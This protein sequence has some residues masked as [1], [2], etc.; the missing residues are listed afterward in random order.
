MK[1]IDRLMSGAIDMHVH[2]GPD[3]YAKRRVD[4]LEIARQAADAGMRAVVFKSHYYCTAPVA[5]MVNKCIGADVLVGSIALN[6][7]VGGLNPSALEAAAKGGAK[8]VWMPT[9]SAMGPHQKN[10]TPVPLLTKT[11][12]LAPQMGPILDIVKTHELVLATGHISA[13][14]VAAVVTEA[15]RREIKVIIT[16]PLAGP[17]GGLISIE[18]AKSYAGMGV[19]IEHCFLAC[20]PPINLNPA[21]MAEYVKA[22]GPEHCIIST[23]HGQATNPPPLE[24]FRNMLECML[25]NGLSES[26]LDTLVRVNPSKLLGFL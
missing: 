24:G 12:E 16:H 17:E 6:V 23:D 19:Y 25:S 2:G 5:S 9:V 1:E 7:H 4:A 14:E 21:L 22:I 26:E 20:M 18:E 13:T 10:Q 11:G 8:I 15:R 3:P